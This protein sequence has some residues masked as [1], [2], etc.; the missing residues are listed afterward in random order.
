MTCGDP[1][2]ASCRRSSQGNVYVKT[3]GVRLRARAQARLAG[4]PLA[5]EADKAIFLICYIISVMLGAIISIT[6]Y[7]V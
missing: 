4:G 5:R 2:A 3:Q 7:D 1:R 6:K